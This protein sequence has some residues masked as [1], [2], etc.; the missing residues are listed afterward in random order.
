MRILFL[1]N[2]FPPEA[3]G[4]FE[5]WAYEASMGLRDRGHNVCV[6]TARAM[7]K[8]PTPTPEWVHQALYLEMDIVPLVNSIRFFTQ[9]SWRERQNLATLKA[10]IDE[11]D[12]EVVMIWG[13]W[14]LHRSLA[15]Y[16][17]TVFG[18]KT[19]YYIGDYWMTLPNQ[20]VH[21]WQERS[22][23]VVAGLLKNSLRPLAKRALAGMSH[24]QLRIPRALFPTQYMQD[25]L[26][27][28]GIAAGESTI[29]TGAV[30]LQ[31]FINPP[32]PVGET[33][34]LLWIGRLTQTKG[35]QTA[36]DAVAQLVHEH[37]CN[38]R[39][40]IVGRGE[41]DFKVK[42]Q[43]RVA[44]L[45]LDKYVTFIVFQPTEKVIELCKKSDILLFTSIWPEPF[46]RVLVEAMAAGLVV[47]GTGTGGSAEIMTPE[48]SLCFE[49]NNHT[50]LA[51][52]I[53]RL[54]QH[55]KLYQSLAEAGQAHVV[56]HFDSDRFV[57][58]I[59]Q[60]LEAVVANREAVTTPLTSNNAL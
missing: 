14:N 25:E 5:L 4:G 1:S 58:N 36:I 60:Y 3:S 6:L 37:G 9:R 18:R 21:Y 8:D 15:A 49:P 19:I 2:F 40:T 29:I 28:Q 42:M 48:N 41:A 56:E 52:Q 20:Y 59:E 43:Q 13:M 34:E 11:F 23:S 24:P 22:N 31:P 7:K 35:V 55:P 54:Q 44:H 17:E 33:I 57:T 39:L 45:N 47:V 12:P 26:H 50:Q 32:K 10:T 51:D 53:L 38:C 30:D 46:G 27:A 16:V